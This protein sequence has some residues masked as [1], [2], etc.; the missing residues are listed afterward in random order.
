MVLH[1]IYFEKKVWQ[2]IE[3]PFHYRDNTLGIGHL[4]LPS[5]IKIIHIKL[6]D[7][8]MFLLDNINSPLT[9]PL[10]YQTLYSYFFKTA[11]FLLPFYF[12]NKKTPRC[13]ISFSC[14]FPLSL[15]LCKIYINIWETDHME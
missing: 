10:N 9:T 12:G 6:I 7:F 2:Q 5:N 11:F 15:W 8:C 4:G 13:I 3:F 14:L 1:I